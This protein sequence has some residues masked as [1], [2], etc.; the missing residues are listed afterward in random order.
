MAE[1]HELARKESSFAKPASK[2]GGNVEK[3]EPDARGQGK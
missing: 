1:Y 2:E 3:L